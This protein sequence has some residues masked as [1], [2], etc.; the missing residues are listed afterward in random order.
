MASAGHAERDQQDEEWLSEW[1][2]GDPW[3]TTRFHQHVL[4]Q[5]A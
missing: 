1:C 5:E 4:H 2:P 3:E